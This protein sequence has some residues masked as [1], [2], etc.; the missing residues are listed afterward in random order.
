[1]ERAVLGRLERIF[2]CNEI[3]LLVHWLVLMSVIFFFSLFFFLH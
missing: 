2:T 1:M 3:E